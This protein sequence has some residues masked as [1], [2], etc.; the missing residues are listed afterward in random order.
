MNAFAPRVVSDATLDWVK[1]DAELARDGS[2]EPVE[3]ALYA[4]LASFMDPGSRESADED[5]FSLNIP[6]RKR[7]A[8]CI[9]RSVDTV[10]RATKRLEERGLLEVE[11]RPDPNNP[12]RHIPS[13]YRLLDHERWDERAAARAAKR[14][15]DKVARTAAR[16]AAKTAKAQAAQGGEGSR[17]HA[18]TPDEIEGG[19]AAPM[20]PGS[21]HG[22]G[23][24]SRTHAA[25]PSSSK[26]SLSQEAREREAA[27]VV[28]GA[29]VT[30]RE[31]KAAPEIIGGQLPGQRS[32][33][34]ADVAVIVAAYREALKRPITPS[35][36]ALLQ[37]DAALL[38]ANNFPAWWLADRAREM[39]PH[40]WKKL[41]DHVDRSKVPVEK[42]GVQATAWCGQCDE[43]HRM[44]FDSTGEYV[45]CETCN[46]QALARRQHESAGSS[47]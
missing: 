43:H 32:Q 23:E 9:G 12:K 25:V 5:E 36:H 30:E 21:P 35:V 33:Q 41:I 45:P 10:D 2:F 42:S 27:G 3:K 1:F 24:G 44:S 11:R 40:G 18:A 26:E 28:G 17:T 16:E 7:L 34:D 38:L 13:L 37:N 19:V 8:E 39:A 20:R 4:A 46:P 14:E 29:A 15:A 22:C 31:T 47:R 6:T